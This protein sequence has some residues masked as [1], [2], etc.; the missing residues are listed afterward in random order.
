MLEVHHR[1]A[2]TQFREI[3]QYQFRID[4]AHAPSFG[5]GLVTEQR[6]LRYDEHSRIVE[7]ER[8]RQ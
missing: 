4:G 8:A 2:W 5:D 7:A 6:G 3:A 1:R